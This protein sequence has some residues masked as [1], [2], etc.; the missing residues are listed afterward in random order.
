MISSSTFHRR[1]SR[2]FDQW[3]R[4]E[5]DAAPLGEI[6]YLLI[7]AGNSDEENPYRKGSAV[8]TYLLG[9]EF[10]STLMLLGK[11]KIYFV[12]SASKAK[13][14]QP[15]AKSPSGS[16]SVEV[17]ILTR[18]KDEAEN[19][20]QFERIIEIVGN[21]N[22]VGTLPK[23]KMAGKFVQ[24]WQKVLAAAEADLK[25]V[26]VALGVSTLLAVK[27]TEELQ[28]ERNA[29]VMTN[30]LMSH[31]SDAMSKYIDEGKKVTHEQLG[32]E[33][34]QK[35]EDN[36]FWSKLKLGD[37]FETGYGDWCYSPIIQSGGNYDLKSSAQTDDARL[38]AGVILCSLGI[39]Y[40]SYCS[41]V[42]RTFMIDPDAQQEKNYLFLVELQKYALAELKDGVVAKDVYQRVADR[43]QADRSDLLP[44]FAKTAGFG[45][46]LEFRDGAYPLGPKGTRTVKTDMIFS[47]TLGFNGIPDSKGSTY[48]VSLVDTVQVGQDGSK[49]LSEGMKGKDDVMFYMDDEEQKPSKS[50]QAAKDNGSRRKPA[51]TA[52]VKSKLRNE[53]RE[54]DLS[55]AVR[56]K[57][58]QREL[59]ARRQEEGLEK[60]SGEGGDTGANREKQWRRF[61][62]YVKDSQLPD[63]VASQ[64]IV[65]DARRATIVLPINGF[66]VPFHVN[67]LK[68][69]IKQEEGDYTVLRFMFTTPGAITG[70]K[71]D[72]PF[73]DPNATFIRGITYR[74]ID[75]FRFAELH[76]EINDLKKVA[77][78]R[79]TERKELA[80]V[81][82]QDRLVEIKGKRPIKLTEVQLR[83][84]FDGKRQT[85][86][87]EIH[88][89]GIRYQSS[90]KSEQKLDILFSNIKHLLF[91]PCDGELIVVLHI[92]LKS[93]IMIGK[94]KAKDVQFFR[95]VSDAS[96]DETGNKKRKRNYHDEDELEAEQEE[97]KRRADLNKYF[98]AFS[99]KI[100]EASN[101]R[102][103][104]DIPFREL[105]F[106]G[107]PFRANVLLQP[108][109]DTLVFLTEPPFLVVT[110][111]EIE[112]AHL[113]RVQYGLKNFDLVFVFQ[114]FTRA[115]IHINTIP[116]NQLD[117]V[118]EWLDSVDIPFSE[119]PVNLN[120]QAI[121]KTVNEDPHD[122]FK[123]GG[124]SF[125]NAQED[126]AGSSES[127]EG[128]EFEADSDVFDEESDEDDSAFSAEASDSDSD[129]GE[130]L[131]DEGEDWSDAEERLASKE[132]GKSRGDSSDD[133]RGKKSK[134]K[135]K[136][137]TN[138][139]DSHHNITMKFTLLTVLAATAAVAAAAPSGERRAIQFGDSHTDLVDRSLEER[140]FYKAGQVSANDPASKR[141]QLEAR[142]RYNSGVVA[143]KDPA[144]KRDLEARWR[145]NSGVVADKDPA[146]K[147]DLEERQ[148]YRAGH[149]STNDPSA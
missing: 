141:D 34:E 26:D 143:D 76:K 119:G 1:A 142:W 31:F 20:K 10:P 8:Q 28:N 96:F 91:Q 15:I 95:E 61:E 57:Q 48:A 124:W 100:A 2:L 92:H 29:A 121:M 148:F 52:V 144:A 50:A 22:K 18:S 128:S 56:R 4:K 105:G 80:D 53:N 86:D 129:A 99:D 147:R 51:A 40:K 7:V 104:V 11:G 49:I 33:I 83:P 111:N 120:W 140:Q 62:S 42:G 73:E 112:I 46:G 54:V 23:D 27:D 89:N 41:N 90:I 69:L 45:M 79:E 98:K 136:S 44:Y 122:F 9:Y 113:E 5:E 88:S 114:D 94:K 35:L 131:S 60:Y 97:R 82:E 146:A 84:S 103:D 58:H 63:A 118:K 110:L 13:L 6:E 102:V 126:V 30:K 77:V 116:M 43:I 14:L 72:T 16:D 59:A 101:G 123:E 145:Y 32:E 115:P 65:V 81:V 38:K 36:K 117:S 127:E 24:E 21:G 87:V 139:Y 107:V 93:P 64:K 134:S 37:G 137:S 135:G 74:S 3:K 138:P 55:A 108:T 66:A 75:S 149:V 19:K 12:V 70:K 67:T 125:L 85:G 68:S 106:Q 25:E 78:K 17:E 130:D 109:T 132:Q 71:E 47:L 133:D 39:R